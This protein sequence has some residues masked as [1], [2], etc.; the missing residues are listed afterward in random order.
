MN[1]PGVIFRPGPKWKQNGGA[2][3]V[4]GVVCHS[5]VGPFEYAMARLDSS[6]EA[7][8]QY[9]VLQNGQVYAH[10]SDETQAW[11]A[12][13]R[14]NN[15]TVGV[16]HEG[17]ADPY[18]EPLTPAQLKASVDLVHWLALAHNF[19]LERGEGLWEHN[20]VSDRPT[21]CPSHRIPW[22]EY[23][24]MPLTKEDKADI[25]QIVKLEIA[26]ARE[27]HNRD[28]LATSKLALEQFRQELEAAGQLP[29]RPPA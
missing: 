20:E 23:T 13:S 17:G 18:T 10:Y 25:G 27:E 6:D 5:M 19:P 15:F 9:S 16:E 21:A 4:R 26:L 7:S 8:W 24:T 28:C 2:N 14:F 12:G 22:E 3:T 11:H 29:P 1:Y